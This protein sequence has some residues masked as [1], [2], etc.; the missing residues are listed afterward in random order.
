[1]RGGDVLSEELHLLRHAAPDDL[2]V[3][4][5]PHR[6]RF[7]IEDFLLDVVLDLPVELLRRRLAAPLRLEHSR[8]PRQLIEGQNDLSRRRRA[9]GGR[10]SRR[11]DWLRC[12]AR[13]NEM[14]R[15]EQDG[16]DRQKLNQRLT[17][18]SR[19]H[20][21][22]FARLLNRNASLGCALEIVD[23]GELRRRVHR[24]VRL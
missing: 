20:Y 13:R 2:V 8:E 19:Q 3:L 23:D 18:H 24:R 12:R 11:L 14:I 10:L 5:E 16:A 4:V 9:R 7:A 1:M 22:H 15:P 17:Q 6:D 21:L